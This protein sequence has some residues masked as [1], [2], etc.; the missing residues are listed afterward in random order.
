MMKTQ[1][2]QTDTDFLTAMDA[3]AENL[4]CSEPIVIYQD[5]RARLDT[6]QEAQTLLNQLGRLQS[7]IRASQ[8]RGTVTQTDVERLRTLQRE[9]Q[10]H[11]TI[12]NYAS[13]QQAAVTHLREINQEISQLLGFDFAAL[14]RP[15]GGCC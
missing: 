3:L 14:A 5:A 1:M 12:S 11:P 8:A 7:E 4:A 10:A 2:N 15:S 6:D 13:T 9:V